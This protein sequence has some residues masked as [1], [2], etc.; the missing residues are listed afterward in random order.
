MLRELQREKT[1]EIE[2]LIHTESVVRKS[3]LEQEILSCSRLCREKCSV[4][5]YD[6]IVDDHLRD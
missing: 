3:K 1:L 2:I 5:V 6:H 4:I